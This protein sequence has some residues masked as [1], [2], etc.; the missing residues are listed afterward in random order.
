M[1]TQETLS[2]FLSY[3]LRHH[4]E[5]IGVTLE[6][7]GSIEVDTL[8]AALAR[9]GHPID[10]AVLDHLV[11]TSDK[12]R[13]AF[14]VDRTKIKANQG[15]SVSVDLGLSPTLPPETLFHGTVARFLPSIRSQ[16]LLK[17]RRHHVH[18][19]AS[20]PVAQAV[21]SRRGAAIVLAVDSAGMATAGHYFYRTDNGV[22]LT[23]WVPA[24]FIRFPPAE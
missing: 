5:A 24:T 14:N 7:D 3:V 16:G 9:H 6:H 11:A 19:S 1:A 22:W 8:L 13:F 17:G 23:E 10:R 15:H 20:S 2:K 18:L 21:G 12:Q 4:P